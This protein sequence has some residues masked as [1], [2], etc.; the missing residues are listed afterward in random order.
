MTFEQ[1]IKNWS[2][3]AF[4]SSDPLLKLNQRSPTIILKISFTAL[5]PPDFATTFFLA[6]IKNESHVSNKFRMQQLGFLLVPVHG[7][8]SPLSWHLSIG[9]LF[10]LELISKLFLLHLKLI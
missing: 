1:Y 6:L 2:S 7:I 4:S 9:S 8:T 10:I 5:F 3:P